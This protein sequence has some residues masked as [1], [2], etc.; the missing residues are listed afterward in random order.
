MVHVNFD[1]SQVRI[2]DLIAQHEHGGYYFEGLPFQRGGMKGAGV[3]DVLRRFWRF[4]VPLAT[5]AGKALAPVAKEIGK[6]GL[7]AG[8]RILSDISEGGDVKNAL[9]SEGR[10]TVGRLLKRAAAAQSGTG[11]VKRRRLAGS[12]VIVKP[13]A[14]DGRLCAVG[15]PKKTRSDALGL[16]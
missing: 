12:N 2:Q 16:Y 10:A 9:V 14:L 3:G 11:K 5:R 8:S 4:V 15:V 13:H 7:I 1:T 6:E